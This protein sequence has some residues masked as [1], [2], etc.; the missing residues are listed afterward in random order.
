MSIS[1]GSVLPTCP[2]SSPVFLNSL[3]A[4]FCSTNKLKFH[5]ETISEAPHYSVSPKFTHSMC[6]YLY[7]YISVY[8]LCIW[9][10]VCF[11]C[12]YTCYVYL[13]VCFVCISCVC[14]YNKC[15]CVFCEYISVVCMYVW[16][17]Y[18]CACVCACA[19]IQ[20]GV[21]TSLGF[22]Q[23]PSTRTPKIQQMLTFDKC[24]TVV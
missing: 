18:I 21:H 12:L 4:P 24:T 8:M 3:S 17:V 10:R 23:F 6:V 13:Y 22:T 19:H 7:V 11:V 20:H 9:V 16:Q 1:R 2:D 14:T 5:Q 15:T